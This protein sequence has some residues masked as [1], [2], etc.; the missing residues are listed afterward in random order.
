V[1]RVRNKWP[2]TITLTSQRLIL[3]FSTDTEHPYQISWKSDLYV[4]IE[5]SQRTNSLTA[6]RNRRQS[7]KATTV[8]PECSC[9]TNHWYATYGASH[10]FCSRS[11]GYRSGNGFCLRWRFWSTSAS[12]GVHHPIWLL[13][14]D[15]C[16]WIRQRRAGLR[17]SSDMMKLDVPPTRT[18]FGDR[19]FAVNGPRRTTRLEQ[20]ASTG[21]NS[22]PIIVTDC[23]SY[24]RLKTHLFVQ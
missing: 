20:S 14:A 11:I 7:V 8:C 1:G 6:L 23:F 13:M 17:S 24:N 2:W 15:D 10:Q 5:K 4:L 3:T 19:S 22:R 9:T 12:T 21:V 18:M 16:R